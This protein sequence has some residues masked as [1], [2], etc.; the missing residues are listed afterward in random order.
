VAHCG[1]LH[2]AP[3]RNTHAVH[4][5]AAFRAH[6]SACTASRLQRCKAMVAN[7]TTCVAPGV[8]VPVTGYTLVPAQSLAT[9]R[10]LVG[11]VCD[12]AL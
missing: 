11:L 10:R 8:V 4:I 5:C 3:I 7:R 6:N 1:G 9:R 2:R 12:T